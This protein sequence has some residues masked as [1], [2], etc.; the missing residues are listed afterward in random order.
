MIEKSRKHLK[1]LF[2]GNVF[3]SVSS[4]L[5][6]MFFWML[7]LAAFRILWNGFYEHPDV[8]IE[9]LTVPSSFISASSRAWALRCIILGVS[10][11][12]LHLT[13]NALTRCNSQGCITVT[14]CFFDSKRFKN[15]VLDAHMQGAL[16]IFW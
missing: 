3:G 9:T 4:G 5:N 7:I 13:S 11:M 1:Y 14:P 15:Y 6:K 2:T 8:L 12:D 10:L 16:P